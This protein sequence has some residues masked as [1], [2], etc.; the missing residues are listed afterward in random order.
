MKKVVSTDFLKTSDRLRTPKSRKKMEEEETNKLKFDSMKGVIS[1]EGKLIKIKPFESTTRTKE[2][3]A[4]NDFF[5]EYIS[6][7]FASPYKK[8]ISNSK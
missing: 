6:G 2:Y 1:F 3:D 4:S 8:R 5:S 7:E